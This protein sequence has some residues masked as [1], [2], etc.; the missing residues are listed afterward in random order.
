MGYPDECIKFHRW[1]LEES[2]TP[3]YVLEKYAISGYPREESRERI[4][5]WQ[6]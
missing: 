2:E 6:I 3:G 5:S 1:A 4:F